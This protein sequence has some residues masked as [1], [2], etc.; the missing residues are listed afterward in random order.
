M[1]TKSTTKRIGII[2]EG[3]V[4]FEDQKVLT[5]LAERIVGHSDIVCLPQGSKPQL[6]AECGKVARQLIATDKC[7]RVIVVWDLEPSHDVAGACR[8]DDRQAVFA[9]LDA[10]G[11]ASHPSVFLVCIE[12]EL[13][14]WLLADGSAI[15][16]VLHRPPHPRPSV[17]DTKSLGEGNPKGRLKRIF[18]DHGYGREFDPKTDGPAIAE[19]LPDNFGALSKFKTFKRFGLK[20]TQPC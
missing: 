17:N 4:D 16:S 2:C 18:K 9:S 11:L 5:H 7:E 6:F 1:A 10:A 15:S 13:E 20:L 3:N 14:T 12:K 8:H 19:A